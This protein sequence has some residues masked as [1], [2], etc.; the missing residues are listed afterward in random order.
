MG[1]DGHRRGYRA[2]RLVVA[3]S[4]AGAVAAGAV[5]YQ[6]TSHTPATVA[7]SQSTSAG[8]FSNT[9]ALQATSQS[10]AAAT[11]AS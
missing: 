7:A 9:N 5:A 8:G 2:R 11:H 10:A 6:S 3:L 4:A 1:S